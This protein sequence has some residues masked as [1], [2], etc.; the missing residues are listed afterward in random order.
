LL[1][2]ANALHA[3]EAPLLEIEVDGRDLPRRILHTSM[4]IPC[5]PGKLRLWYPKW[6]PGTHGPY[7]RVEDI[8]GLKIE[9]DQ[10]KMV[11]WKRDEVEFH[12][13]VCQVPA[14]AAA[15]L[16]RLD[17][18]CNN[19]SFEAAGMFS[20]GNKSLG[21]FKWNT[22]L[23]Y[24][25]GPSVDDVRARLKLILPWRW[26]FA[27]A[28][29]VDE[30][31]DNRIA[32]AAVSLS[33]L[34]DSPLIAG[35]HLRSFKL[36]VGKNP[37]AWLDVVSE[38]PKAVDLPQEV[39]ER[40]SAV[41]REACALFGAAHY[42]EYH[43]L[44]TCSDQLGY[45]GLEHHYCSING[46]KERDLIDND[47]RRGW[48]ANLLPHEYAHSWCGKF[49]RP[50]DMCT[51]D[52]HSPQKTRLLWVYEGLTEYLGELLMVRSGLVKPTDYV[53]MLSWTL[54]DEVLRP[55][56]KWR[57]LE[58]TAVASPLLRGASANWSDLRRDQDYY[59]EG[60]L[61]WL[62][63]DLIVRD[64]SKGKYSLDDF[65]KRFMGP[66]SSKDKVV[67]YDLSE[68]VRILKE[69]ADHDWE[70]FFTRRVSL[71]LESLPLDVV[72]M[73]GYK[74]GYGTKASGHI[75]FLQSANSNHAIS[76][77]D[78]LGLNLGHD[79]AVTG[80][81]SGSL[82]DKAGFVVGCQILGV[83]NK[84]FTKDYFDAALNDSVTL[85]KMQ[86]IVVENDNIRTVTVDYAGGP[87]FFE[88]SRDDKKKDV[89]GEILKATAAK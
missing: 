4:K 16:V 27:S 22:C 31:T 28:L 63:V 80:I 73:A 48:I 42:P 34:I 41:V 67:P 70:K 55:G 56:R 33:E 59:M 23:L 81:V 60:M 57:P 83:N 29:K 30:A 26:K 64:V 40:Y 82:A 78:S 54:G 49:R 85:K 8:A 21:I 53:E 47:K 79:G 25:E 58:D 75:E 74:I 35:E 46:V 77:R 61:L 5:Q 14:G 37:P 13:V 76:A 7:G 62:E 88:L 87:R 15:V 89:L 1:L 69:L 66:T 65:C 20:Y 43:F 39:V 71:P 10:G 18:I 68:I 38:S 6:L 45:L 19:A 24:P 11:E 51:S 32:F 86:F 3:A 2:F 12:C 17:T 72:G 84:K 36:D 9:T 50:K 44:V 52:F